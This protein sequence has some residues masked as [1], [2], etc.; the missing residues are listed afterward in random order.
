ME[1][2]RQWRCVRADHQFL[3]LFLLP[4]A[5]YLILARH[6]W[7]FCFM[8]LII[9]STTLFSIERVWPMSS[10][11]LYPNNTGYILT[12]KRRVFFR[13]VDFLWL[14]TCSGVSLMS[15]VGR[16]LRFA[17]VFWQWWV[18]S[19]FTERSVP[20]WILHYTDTFLCIVL[21]WSFWFSSEFL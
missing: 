5:L 21:C 6:E 16:L 4:P 7:I 13:S 8:V 3:V 1:A 17:S 15:L 10:L 9:F 19:A 18:E 11:S 2:A 20:L 12:E 14:L